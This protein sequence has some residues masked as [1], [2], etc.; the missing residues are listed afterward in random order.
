MKEVKI[1]IIQIN[2]KFMQVLWNSKVKVLWNSKVKFV[3]VS[4]LLVLAL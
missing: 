3:S 1:I 4:Q 2:S